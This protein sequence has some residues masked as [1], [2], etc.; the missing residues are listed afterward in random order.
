MH[1]CMS[2]LRCRVLALSRCR[3]V[4]HG[5]GVCLHVHSMPCKG[6]GMPMCGAWSRLWL[7]LL[8]QLWRNLQHVCSWLTRVL[9][10]YSVVS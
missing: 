2:S 10:Y 3:A 5:R 6:A 9:S 8:R 4:A 7:E 1:V